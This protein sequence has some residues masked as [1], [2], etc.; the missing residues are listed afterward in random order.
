MQRTTQ[1]LIA[2]ALSLAFAGS[3]NAAPT[4]GSRIYR[5]APKYKLKKTNASAKSANAAKACLP[6]PP[7]KWRSPKAT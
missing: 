6:Y 1:T 7:P 3:L 5:P 2:L 4:S